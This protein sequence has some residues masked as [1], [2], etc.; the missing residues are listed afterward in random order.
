MVVVTEVQGEPLDNSNYLY[1]IVLMRNFREVQPFGSFVFVVVVV[2]V[3]VKH[4]SS[5]KYV[6]IS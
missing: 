3:V 5:R 1:N 4:F 6:I 2:V